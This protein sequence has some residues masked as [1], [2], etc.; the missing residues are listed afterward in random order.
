MAIETNILDQKTSLD[1]ADVEECR[2]IVED[3]ITNPDPGAKIIL[4]RVVT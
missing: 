4:S 2:K 1:Q 3:F